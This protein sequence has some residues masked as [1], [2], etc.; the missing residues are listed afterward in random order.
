MNNMLFSRRDVQQCIYR[1]GAVVSRNDLLQFVDALNRPGRNRII[2]LWEVVVLDALSRVSPIR[3]EQPLLDGQQP[4]FAFSLFVDGQTVDVIGDIRCVSDRG[5]DNHNPI[6]SLSSEIVRVARKKRVDPAKLRIQVQGEVVGP[7]R[8]AKMTLSL[9]AKGSIAEFVRTKIAPFLESVKNASEKSASINIEQQDAILTLAYNP[10]QMFFSMGHPSYDVSYSIDRNPLWSALKDKADQLR[11]SPSNSIRLVIICDGDCATLKAESPTGVHFST[12]AIVEDFL[13]RTSTVDAVLLLPVVETH[14]GTQKNSVF[15]APDFYPRRAGE[16]VV[17]SE[18][19][20]IALRTHLNN[21]L[22]NMPKPCL[23][24]PSAVNWCEREGVLMGLHG[25]YAISG[26]TMRISSRQILET[27]AGIPSNGLPPLGSPPNAPL[28]PAD[29]QEHFLRYLQH[30]QMISKVTV[31]PGGDA[32][33]DTLE[34]EFGQPDPAI[35]P[36]QMP[37]AP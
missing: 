10:E 21:F 6:Q 29:W 14:H 28:P 9:P 24:A 36:F 34:F 2:K 16:R 20:E 12:K 30:G 17:M 11:A 15:L 26:N 8:D 33:D 31:I 19:N 18:Q 5:L 3:H 13:R 27:L 4:D 7:Y 23:N 35:H 32:D 22:A 25:G 37:K 1:L